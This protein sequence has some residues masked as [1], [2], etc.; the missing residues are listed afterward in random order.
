MKLQAK[1][2]DN[3]NAL[4]KSYDLESIGYKGAGIL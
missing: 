1:S 4:R 3:I 2:V